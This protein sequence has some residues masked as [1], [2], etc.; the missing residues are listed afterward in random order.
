[1]FARAWHGDHVALA[2][3]NRK[4]PQVELA[5]TLALGSQMDLQVFSQVRA[6]HKKHTSMQTYPAFHFNTE[7]VICIRL[8]RVGFCVFCN[9]FG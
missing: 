3:Q 6:S 2:K 8:R 9:D 1:M 5:Y 4:Q 7:T